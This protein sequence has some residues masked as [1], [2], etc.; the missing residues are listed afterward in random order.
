MEETHFDRVA[1]VAAGGSRRRVLGALLAGA[2]ASLRL[3]TTSADQPG[4]VVAEAGG[5]DHNLATVV[6]PINYSDKDTRETCQ[7]DSERDRCQGR[8]DRVVNDDCGGEIKCTCD[9][10]KVC[11]RE[12]GVYRQPDLVCAGKCDSG[13]E[14]EVCGPGDACC[15]IERV[16]RRSNACCPAGMFCTP[17]GGTCCVPEDTCQVGG[18]PEPACCTEIG[19]CI[20]DVCV[21]N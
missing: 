11:A 19:T 17:G 13:R 20:G 9:G 10:E 4:T 1:R 8:C 14:G 5:G 6:E 15:P 3:H 16:C 12:D 18:V 21:P 2:L 7:P